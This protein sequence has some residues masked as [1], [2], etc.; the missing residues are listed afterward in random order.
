MDAFTRKSLSALSELEQLETALQRGDEYV[1]EARE[2]LKEL[3]DVSDR[4]KLLF[5][6]RAIGMVASKAAEAAKDKP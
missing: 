1:G 6:V 2:L 4:P 5:W 3:I